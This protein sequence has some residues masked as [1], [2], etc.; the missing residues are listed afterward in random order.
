MNLQPGVHGL[1]FPSRLS[2]LRHRLHI[3]SAKQ[4][5]EWVFPCP[6]ETSWL[7]GHAGHLCQLQSALMLSVGDARLLLNNTP[8]SFGVCLQ[9][10]EPHPAV[11]DGLW[12]FTV[13]TPIPRSQCELTTYLPTSGAGP[14]PQ[15]GRQLCSGP[16]AAGAT[17]EHTS[18]Y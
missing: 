7:H 5:E 11:Q 2:Q 8:Q 12:P 18:V 4:L 13:P 14:S 6:S 1:L 10:L 15:P 16:Q 17:K 9:E 3:W